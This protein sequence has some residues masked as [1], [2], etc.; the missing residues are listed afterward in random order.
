MPFY[1][2]RHTDSLSKAQRDALAEAI[3][4]IHSKKFTTPRLFVNVGFA[5]TSSMHTYV[6]GKERMGNSISATVRV[7]P[8]RTQKDWDELCEDVV[9]AW[10]EILPE[11]ELRL[12]V[13]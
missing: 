4:T 11:V 8:S 1:E 7:G 13:R 10:K 3:T 9:A 12:V 5:D 2:V 6:A